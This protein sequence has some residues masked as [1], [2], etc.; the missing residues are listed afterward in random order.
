MRNLASATTRAYSADVRVFK[1]WCKQHS[2]IWMP[3]LAETVISFLA[4]QAAGGISRS[5]LNRR[6][7]AI[8]RAHVEAGYEPPTNLE[9]FKRG[10]RE[11]TSK[12]SRELIRACDGERSS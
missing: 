8:R 1:G 7:A 3:A 4:A 10:K 12:I 5:T 6:A 2:R 11:I 9:V